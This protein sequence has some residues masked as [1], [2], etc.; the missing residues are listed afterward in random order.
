[1]KIIITKCD[2]G[3]SVKCGKTT[4]NCKDFLELVRHLEVLFKDKMYDIEWPAP[5]DDKPSPFKPWVQPLTDPYT[6][7]P[8]TWP[9]KNHKCSKCGLK[10]ETIMHY[11]CTNSPCPAGLGG[12]FCSNITK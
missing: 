7:E 6:I 1:M 8:Y 3:Y 12:V 5:T 2:N 4:H 10:L 11:Y 9:P